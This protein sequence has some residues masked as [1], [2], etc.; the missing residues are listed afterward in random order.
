VNFHMTLTAMRGLYH[1]IR[2]EMQTAS[3][4]FI[5]TTY[6]VPS[7]MVFQMLP[8]EP[9]LCLVS[10]MLALATPHKCQ[11]AGNEAECVQAIVQE[12]HLN[13]LRYEDCDCE[14]FGTEVALQLPHSRS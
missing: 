9:Q 3:E 6:W 2:V 5:L 11:M 13:Q 12:S 1:S 8:F 4:M 14:I 10:Q 7:V